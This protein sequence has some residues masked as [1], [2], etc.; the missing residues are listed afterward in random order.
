[1]NQKVV[2]LVRSLVLTLLFAA[3]TVAAHSQSGLIREVYENIPNGTLFALTN[4]DAN[5]PDF[6]DVVGVVPEFEAPQSFGDFYGQSVHGYILPPTNGDYI[7]WIASDDG[8]ALFI[9]TDE[10]PANRSL[11]A[12][13]D[14]YVGFRE[15]DSPFEPKQQSRPITLEAGKRYFIEALH[16]EGGGGDHMTVRWQLP[17]GTIEEPIPGSRLI[18]ELIPPQIT[19]QPQSTNSVENLSALFTLKLANRAPVSVQWLLNGTAIPGETNETLFLPQ[20]SIAQNGQRYSAELTNSFGINRTTEATLTVIRDTTPPSLLT[21]YAPGPNNLVAV[22]FS[23]PV[24]SSSANL[25]ENYSLS[26]GQILSAVLDK[27]GVTVLLRTT[28]LQIGSSY[29]LT[30]NN[31]TDLASNPNNIE[32]ESSATFSYGYSPVAPSLIYG[33]PERIGPSSRRTGLIISEIMYHPSPREDGVNLE[34]VEL[35]NSSAS[36]VSLNDYRIEGAIQYTFPQGSFISAGSYLVLASAPNDLKVQTGLPRVYGPYSGTLQN[37]SGKLKLFNSQGAL[38]IDASYGSTSPWPV[39]PDGAGHSLVLSRPSYG[40]AD[41]R[42]Y[43]QSALTGGSPGNNEPAIPTAFQSVVI[44]EFLAH[45]VA[46]QLDFIELFNYSTNA[47]NISGCWLS[48]SPTTNKFRFPANSI[49]PPLGFIVVDE[50]QLGFSLSGNGESVYLRDPQRTRV[51]DSFRFDSQ[52]VGVSMGRWP[53]GNQVFRPLAQTTPGEVNTAPYRESIIVSE[54]MYHPPSGGGNGEYVELYN[55]GTNTVNLGGWR[56]DTGISFVF[57]AGSQ[58]RPGAYAVVASDSSYLRSVY[59]NLT[60]DNTFGNFSGNLSNGG[61]TLRLL[62]PETVVTSNT[63]G[64]LS[65]NISNVTVTSID[66][67]TGGRWG[68]WSDGGGSSLELIDSEAN[69]NIGSSWADSDES[70]KSHWI[71]IEKRG[72]LDFGMTNFSA[73]NPSKSLHIFLQDA[74]EALVDNVQVIPDGSTNV[75]ANST[76][77][78]GFSDW[79]ATGT[80]ELTKLE[81]SEGDASARSMHVRAVTRGDTSSNRIRGKLQVGLKPNTIA[82]ISARARWLAGTPEILFRLHGNYLEA[83]GQLPIP[84]NLGTPGLP[85]SRANPN[86]GPSISQIQHQPILPKANLPFTVLAQVADAQ[87]VAVVT[88]AYR[89]DPSTN[90]IRVPMVN[91]GAGYFQG[92]IPGMPQGQM[93]AFSIEALN[94]KGGRS[95]FPSDAPFREAMILVGS[96]LQGTLGNYQLWLSSSNITR[97]TKRE[98]SSNSGLDATFAYNGDRVIYNM[99]TLFSGSPYHW[100]GYNGPLGNFCNYLI[101]MPPDDLFLGQQDAVLN[102]PSNI[103]SDDTAIREQTAFWMADQIHQPANNRRYNFLT[104]NGQFRGGPFEDAQQPNGDF[105]KQWFPNDSNGDLFKIEDW[106]EFNDSYGFQNADATLDKWTT[107]NL[108]TNLREPKLERY[109]WNFRKRAASEGN[110]DYSELYKLVDALNNTNSATYVSRIKE[111]IDI[112]EWMGAMAF[113]H[114]IGDWDSYGYRRGKNMYAYKPTAGKWNLLHWDIAF[115]FGLGDGPTSDI[116]DTTHFDGTIDKITARMMQE[117]TLRRAYMRTIQLLVDGPFLASRVNSAIDERYAG[118]SAAY[119]NLPGPTDSVKQWIAERRDFLLSQLSPVNTAF[120]LLSPTGTITTNRNQ[121][122]LIGT[123]PVS[124]KTI[125]INGVVYDVDWTSTTTWTTHYALPIGTKNVVIQ[126]F[127]VNDK[128]VLAATS[129]LTINYNGPT[130]KVDDRVVINE[131]QTHPSIDGAEFVELYNN[132]RSVAYDLISTRL[133]GVDFTFTNS[134]IIAPGGFII[135]AK[136][137]ENYRAAYPFALQPAGVYAGKL[138]DSGDTLSLERFD[139][140]G[141]NAIV[142]DAVTFENAL[143]W[144]VITTNDG[145]SL[146]LIDSS[147]DGSRVGNWAITP[148]VATP[149]ASNSVRLALAAFPAVWLN[150]ISTGNANQIADNAGEFDSWTEIFNPTTNH[151]SLSGLSLSDDPANLTKWTFPAGAEIL[152]GEFLVVWLDGQTAQT[153]GRNYHT[154][155]KPVSGASGFLAL[156]VS[157]QGASRIISYLNYPA[158]PSRYSYGAIPDGQAHSLVSMFYASPGTTNNA[159]AAPVAVTINEWMASNTHTIADQHNKFSDWFELYNAGNSP[160]VLSGYSL[161]NNLLNQNGQVIP[162]GVTIP[163]KGFLLIW[164]DDSGP[165]TDGSNGPVHISFKLSAKGESI[166]LFDPNGQQIDAVAFGAQTPD[167]SEGRSTDGA[168]QPFVVLPTATPG[169]S[170]NPA[171]SNQINITAY[172]ASGSVVITWNVSP[173]ANYLIQYKNSLSEDWSQGTAANLGTF[174][175]PISIAH[176]FY[177][178]VQP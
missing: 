65:T 152:P 23:E 82:T 6:P 134:T 165:K 31:V 171:E 174:S 77:E 53:D 163:A 81:L 62:R 127:D 148:G 37:S 175:E 109:R 25:I 90:V 157:D 55:R 91:V 100:S 169:A 33:K 39:A 122:T 79:T 88:L 43:S 138:R 166:A 24:D 50:T 161:A 29:T 112:D 131:I 42:A 159:T 167:V 47:V 108:G 151:V 21:A 123:A 87:G 49:L 75:V 58:L 124:V 116:F 114:A 119:G 3:S 8:S 2:S 101:S 28:P 9:S 41:P 176:R 160:A 1:M 56:F 78:N 26:G 68:Q 126:G 30:V 66:Y 150:E 86:F 93:V 12:E 96:Q 11:I 158:L 69:P 32:P 156:S 115:A 89:K 63:N 99:H 111:L 44:N 51:I 67:K 143:P 14:N 154:S 129:T 70:R 57:A 162:S 27:D 94:Q 13:V 85:N 59:T 141:T 178:V 22:V 104:L 35:F 61:E 135:V 54:I 73:A 45:S 140:S 125:R 102:L 170:N 117:P 172:L 168:P 64:T 137:L 113:R 4:Q 52:A 153:S 97:W 107:T 18:P 98:S 20:L 84:A 92:T 105:V 139:A 133:H 83:V 120:G 132:S 118:L 144:P 74:G 71:T 80:Q 48:D 177:R 103:L 164:A 16:A 19:T 7:F 95:M 146:Q 155:F 15:F 121:F 136:D 60:A 46:P 173:G 149:G 17:S 40:E 72:I 36:V 110:S 34:F 106:F 142:I 128:P 145:T 147:R 130:D 5:F 10:N 38:L 76:F